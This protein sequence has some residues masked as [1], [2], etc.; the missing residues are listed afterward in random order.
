[1]ITIRQGRKEDAAFIAKGVAMA[2]G[3]ESIRF[4]CG[5]EYLSVLAHIASM[6]VSQYSYRNA[7]IAEAD[8][9][10]VGVALSYD[11]N[12][13]AALRAP[14]LH[15]IFEATGTHHRIPDETGPGELYL[16]TLAVLPE[17]RGKGI[18]GKLIEAVKERAKAMDLPA[19]GLL[20]DFDNHP[21]QKL[22]AAHGFRP[23]GTQ[24]F[25]GHPMHHLLAPLVLGQS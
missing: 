19:T 12:R 4:Y 22:Y 9:D 16:D 3:E 15:Y 18:G 11:G 8:G 14:T 20:V 13:L 7:L 24:D 10:R 17:V 21:A 2:I 6:E 1:M 23:N 5:E 25:L